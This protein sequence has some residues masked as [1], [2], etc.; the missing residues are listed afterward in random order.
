MAACRTVDPPIPLLT[1]RCNL[2]SPWVE[3]VSAVRSIRRSIYWEHVG[4]TLRFRSLRLD[5]SF[6]AVV[7]VTAVRVSQ[8]RAINLNKNLNP[9]PHPPWK[10]ALR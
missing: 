9:S 6:A 7:P 4:V 2:C 3:C 10:G 1:I 8:H 5:R